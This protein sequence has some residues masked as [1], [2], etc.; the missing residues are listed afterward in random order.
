VYYDLFG[1]ELSADGERVAMS[2]FNN[3]LGRVYIYRQLPTLWLLEAQLFEGYYFGMSLAL[4]GNLLAVGTPSL[5]DVCGQVFYGHVSI[6]RRDGTIWGSDS[7]IEAPVPAPTENFG[8]SLSL[9]NGRL[10]VGAPR[11]DCYANAPV[12]AVYVYAWTGGSWMMEAKLT[13]SD[14]AV[15]EVFGEYVAL[16]GDLLA[17]GAPRADHSGL[18]DA[19]I[20]YIFRHDGTSWME[21]ETLM[22]K[23][24]DENDN[25]GIDV[26]LTGVRVIAG[27]WGDDEGGPQAGAAYIF[28]REE[29]GWVQEAKLFAFEPALG[30]FFGAAPGIHGPFAVVGATRADILSEADTGAAFVF[31]RN[32]TTWTPYTR[33]TANNPSTDDYFGSEIRVSNQSVAVAALGRMVSGV[34]YAGAVETFELAD[35]NADTVLNVCESDSDMD[36]LTDPCDNCPGLPNSAQGDA[37]N[38]GVGDACDNCPFDPNPGQE[39]C[40]SN[41]LG[42][43]CDCTVIVYGDVV[44]SGQVDVDDLGCLVACFAGTPPCFPVGDIYPCEGDGMCDVDDLLALVYA[45]GGVNFCPDSCVPCFP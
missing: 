18:N 8:W 40:D 43:A 14:G 33:L 24:P 38:D 20:V 39:D 3:Y 32:G 15:A 4:E 28:R 45:F 17:V 35:C 1:F 34:M 12:G 31:R 10:A 23:D 25:F 41:G 36:G 9:S 11:R 42:D 6:F 2:S 16:E 21:E 37:E 22:P 19:G 7:A 26:G 44:Y 5:S 30:D 29:T 13:P 27:A